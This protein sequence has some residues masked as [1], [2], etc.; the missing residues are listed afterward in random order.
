M[1]VPLSIALVSFAAIQQTPIAAPFRAAYVAAGPE[2]WSTYDSLGKAG[3]SF[4]ISNA[5]SLALNSTGERVLFVQGGEH[6][7]IALRTGATSFSV[8]SG[9]RDATWAPAGNRVAFLN[10]QG[11]YVYNASLPTETPSLVQAGVMQFSWSA[12]GQRLLGFSPAS[13]GGKLQVLSPEGMP[14]TILEGHAMH[15]IAWAPNGRHYAFLKPVLGQRD[16]FSLIV[17]AIGASKL[18]NIAKSVNGD[19]VWSPDSRKVLI[20]GSAS[21][22][23]AD[24]ASAEPIRLPTAIPPVLAWSGSHHLVGWS[25]ASLVKLDIRRTPYVIEK[26]IALSPAPGN[27][28]MVALAP[29]LVVDNAV[30]TADPFRSLSTPPAGTI[31]VRGYVDSRDPIE[32]LATMQV[33]VIRTPDGREQFMA[34]P[35]AVKLVVPE[36][37]RQLGSDLPLRVQDLP[38]DQEIEV[39]LGGSSLNGAAPVPVRWAYKPNW[40]DTEFLSDPR[41]PKLPKELNFIWRQAVDETVKVPLI[42]PAVGK[43]RLSDWWMAS[44]GGGTRKHIGQDIMADKMTPIV[45]CFDGTV[46]V[47]RGF[48]NAGNTI[49]LDHP[50][51]WTAQYYHVNNDNPGT[52]DGQGGD[53]HAFAPGIVNGTRVVAGQFLG[54]VGDSGNAESTGPHIHFELWYEPS[55]AVI[56]AFPSLM[57]ATKLAQPRYP[58][59]APFIRPAAGENRVDGIVSQVNPISRTMQYAEVAAFV[60]GKPFKVT[61]Y[62]TWAEA[63]LDAAK[64]KVRLPEGASLRPDDVRPGMEVTLL[65]PRSNP[66]QPR[67][68]AVQS[69]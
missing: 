50:S 41:F 44:R 69:R 56:N 35:I 58:D 36:T 22:W 37:A 57:A 68:V 27:S 59:P 53:S 60:E 31:Q 18:K 23:L 30:L 52:D 11:L 49:T 55:R 38:L 8:G 9:A 26:D 7:V 5:K 15:R 14:R 1:L 40:D 17:G 43:T 24:I 21:A 12:D 61:T 2:K 64:V 3:P 13:S 51:G 32:D 29:R 65:V 62:P 20:R 54:W 67:V 33:S 6:K 46:S 10:A 47:G 28:V 34:R 63:Q 39:S 19:L 45:A 4:E 16:K 42:F 25:G 66:K 48:G